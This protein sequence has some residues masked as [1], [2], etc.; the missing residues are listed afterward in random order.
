MGSIDSSTHALI[1]GHY[2][3]CHSALCEVG[4]A[5]EVAD[6]KNVSRRRV[7]VSERSNNHSIR[8]DELR[9]S[10][11]GHESI[12]SKLGKRRAK[13]SVKSI[14]L[15]ILMKKSD[16]LLNI[17]KERHRLPQGR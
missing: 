7:V 17:L 8:L 15:K 12:T 11:S 6:S 3:E 13:V 10:S 1:D 5:D 2:A 16:F 9:N 4:I 14:F